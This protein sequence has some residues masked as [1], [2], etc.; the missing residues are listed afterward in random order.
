MMQENVFGLLR[1]APWVRIFPLALV[2]R[3]PRE[4]SLLGFSYVPILCVSCSCFLMRFS[5]LS[6]S[7]RESERFVCFLSWGSVFGSSDTLRLV[8]PTCRFV[9]RHYIV[10]KRIKKKT[11]IPRATK[12]REE[13]V[14]FGIPHRYMPL[15]CVNANAHAHTYMHMKVGKHKGQTYTPTLKF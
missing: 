7:C 5:G 4:S 9:A 8:L 2:S 13:N 3:M 10:K 1:V 14:L 15:K 12:G 11:K 6:L